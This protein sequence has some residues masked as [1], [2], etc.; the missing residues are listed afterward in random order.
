MEEVG[1]KDLDSKT[2]RHLITAGTDQA[3]SSSRNQRKADNR[4]RA[5]L[6]G[7]VQEMENVLKSNKLRRFILAGTPEV[8]E[9]V[10]ERAVE[11][12]LRNGAKI[13]VVTGNAA[14]GLRAGG[15][16]GAFLKT[17]TGTLEV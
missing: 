13:E 8:V 9:N 5:N 6:R 17:R 4:V 3:G 7:L 15:G 11:H 12:A 14:A 2:V 1:H 16:I 10:V